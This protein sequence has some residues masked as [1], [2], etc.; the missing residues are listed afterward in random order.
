[1]IVGE[2]QG[3]WVGCHNWETAIKDIIETTGEI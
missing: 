3:T 1:M 2:M